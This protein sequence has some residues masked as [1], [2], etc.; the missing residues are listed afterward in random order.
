MENQTIELLGQI[1]QGA[2]LV[3]NITNFVV[4]NAS[5]NILLAIGASPVM[6]HSTDEVEE[7]AAMAGALVLNIGTLDQ[8][9][10]DAMVRA[11][12]AANQ[13]GIPVVLDP[14]G[15]GATQFRTH[16]V[17]KILSACRISVLRGN[18]SEVLSLVSEDVRTRG[19]ESVL[20]LPDDAVSELMALAA[21]NNCI[22]AVSGQTDC[23]TDGHRVFRVA[24]GHRLMTRV[25]GTGCGLSAVTSAFCAV[26]PDRLLE[27][28]V[29]AFA[30][31]GRC[32]E[33]AASVSDKPGS[34]YTAFLDGLYS[35]G[36]A[37]ITKG[38]KIREQWGANL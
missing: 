36:E 9:W 15:A 8:T 12:R 1:R 35:A 11:G 23:I 20:G 6:A 24:N 2:P 26:A 14:V 5:A 10:L 4:M 25:T 19:V 16:A 32:A 28:A 31:Y 33:L 22:V 3:H 29:A 27:A 7:M 37:E 30:F 38:L 21:A 13:K 17:E 18:V 34:F